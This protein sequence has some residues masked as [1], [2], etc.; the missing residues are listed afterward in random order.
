[1]PKRVG[2]TVFAIILGAIPIF[3]VKTANLLDDWWKIL[4]IVL[5]FNYN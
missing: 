3:K 5:Y 4:K 1:M 2:E